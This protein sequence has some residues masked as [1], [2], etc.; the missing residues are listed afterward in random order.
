MT[1]TTHLA[2]LLAIAAL[3]TLTACQ[4]QAEREVDGAV[5]WQSLTTVADGDGHR[6]P[7]RMNESEFHYVDDPAVALSG[8]GDS[9][10]A[11]VDNRAKEIFL[12]RIDSRGE[13]RDAGPTRV[14][15]S[16]EV[17]S[18][19][20][21]LIV[22][23]DERQV[24]VTWQEI[25]FTGG[26]HG[27]EILLARSEDG[28]A[29]FAEPVNLS[30]S[31]AGAGKGR[32]DAETWDNGSLDLVLAADGTVLVA[33]TEYEGRLKVVHSTDGGRSFSDPVHVAGDGDRPAR[34]P[35][36][37]AAGDT[38]LVAWTFGEDPAADIHIAASDDRGGSFSTPRPV[39]ERPGHADAPALA[40]ADDG[41][42]HL[43]H[44][45]G[46]DGPQGPGQLVYTRSAGNP[47]TFEPA[48]VVL[49]QS[50]RARAHAGFPELAAAGEQVIIAWHILELERPVALGLGLMHSDN[51]GGR[52]SG[53]ELIPG[54][55]PPEGGIGGGLQGLLTRK[56]ATD[57]SGSVALAHS[58]FV[59]DQASQIKLVRG[60]LVEP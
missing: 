2:S 25:E 22:A 35:A 31:R 5:A 15:S 56:L 18:W 9:L 8:D 30:N 47:L 34:A 1:R 50:P 43:V 55:E 29:S 13:P 26:S 24:L 44:A 41:T 16:P 53:P 42:V 51:G 58:L 48:R 11:W 37:T 45:E 38:V 14:S 12:T 36:L 21:R 23:P 60:R 6:G 52:F 32:L 39:H 17:F 20:P 27:G 10:V 57:A 40:V 33:W 54:T 3:T 59:P 4:P 28:G 46:R 7:W 49:E 19:L